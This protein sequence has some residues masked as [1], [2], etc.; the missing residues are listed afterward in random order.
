MGDFSG[1]GGSV[2]GT[3]SRRSTASTTTTTSP[4]PPPSSATTSSIRSSPFSSSWP[5]WRPTSRTSMSRW[6]LLARAHAL[7]PAHGDEHHREEPARP[8]GAP[9]AAPADGRAGGHALLRVA[10]RRRRPQALN[11]A[12]DVKESRPFW[13]TELLAFGMTVGS[14]ALVLFGIAGLIAG[15]RLRALGGGQARHRPGLR[16]RLALAALA[17]DGAAHHVVRGDRLLR[18]PR[19]RAGVQIHHARLGGGD[20]GLA[21]RD[22][23]VQPVRQPLRQLQRHLRIDRRRRPVD[24]LVLYHRLHLL[25]GRRINAILEAASDEGKAWGAAPPARRPR[26][27]HSVRARCPPG[28][29]S[30]PTSRRNGGRRRATA[31]RPG[32]LPCQSPPTRPRQIIRADRGTAWYASAKDDMKIILF[33]G[34][35]MVGQG[36]LRECLR[37]PRVD[38]GAGRSA[39]RR[40]ARRTASCSRSSTADFTRFSALEA[41][42]AGSDACFFCLGV[43]SPG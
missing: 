8:G 11:L 19:R 41:Q 7:L 3:S 5:R 43:S 15:G 14:A 28:R 42:L 13:K 29:P 37:D 2:G 20:A 34:S 30:A 24:D 22:L 23:G 38:R 16:L 17:G 21:A 12:Y 26:R 25:D 4:T 31:R 32:P 6:R 39:G 40:S 27:P 33:G 35:G 1:T 10:R 9:A 36:V 18:A